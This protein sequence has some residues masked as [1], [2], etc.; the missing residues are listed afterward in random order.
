VTPGAE[1]GAHR[2]EPGAV[3]WLIP[4]AL[5]LHNAEEAATFSHYLPR[6]TARL[7]DFA[8]PIVASIDVTRLWIALATATVVPFLVIAWA[9]LR[10]RSLAARWSALA[11]LAVV[12]LNVVSH[13]VVAVGVVRGYAPGLV[14]ALAV[15]AP[16]STVLFR[17]AAREQWIPRWSWWLLLPTAFLVHGPVLLGLLLVA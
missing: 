8:Q 3:L 17:R 15:N 12:S 13:V 2:S 14:T 16:V 6:S 10:P 9:A 11:V 7:P 5:A 1:R 4:L